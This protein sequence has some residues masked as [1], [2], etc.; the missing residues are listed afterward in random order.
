MANER[1]I[2]LIDRKAL[3]EHIGD[4]YGY[5]AVDILHEIEIFPGVDAVEVVHGR[6]LETLVPDGYV[7]KASRLR[8][9]CSVCGWTN[10]CRYNFCPN[11][12]A[13]MDGGN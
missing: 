7:P 6:W 13:K 4:C 3:E 9:Q 12:G 11:C 5:P 2:D 10:A 8:K 1:R